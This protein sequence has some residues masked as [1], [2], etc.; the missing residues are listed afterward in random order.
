MDAMKDQFET[1]VHNSTINIDISTD[2]KKCF[3]D[4]LSR[5]IDCVLFR[6]ENH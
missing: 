5:D 1:T 6:I 4:L 2:I 3:Q